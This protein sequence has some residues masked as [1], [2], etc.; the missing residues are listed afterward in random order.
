MNNKN[1]Y[2]APEII[3]TKF[4]VDRDIMD[5]EANTDEWVEMTTARIES[6]TFIPTQGFDSYD[7]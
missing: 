2:E 3:I 7:Y 5:D 6:T 1:V 4:E